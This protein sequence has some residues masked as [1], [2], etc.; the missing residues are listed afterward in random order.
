MLLRMLPKKSRVLELG[1]A[2]GYMSKIMSDELDCNVVGIEIEEYAGKEAEKYCE[3][4]IIEDLNTMDF[5]KYFH[6]GRI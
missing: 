6:V 3:K 2:S 1:C 5:G 4:V